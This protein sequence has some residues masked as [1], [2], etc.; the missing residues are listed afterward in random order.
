MTDQTTTPTRDDAPALAAVAAEFD[1]EVP[2]GVDAA[3]MPQF[4]DLTRLLPADRLDAQ[5][6]LA[7]IAAGLPEG[8]AERMADGMA[9]SDFTPDVAASLRGIFHAMQDMVLDNAADRDAMT[10]WLLDQKSPMSALQ[11][12]F[13]KVSAILGN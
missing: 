11:Y 1:T 4:R 5:L 9:L 6:A 3:T 10:A 2:D 13:A 12:A 8:A 7:E